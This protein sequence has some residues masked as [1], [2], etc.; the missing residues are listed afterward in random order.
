[1][2][3]HQSGFTLIELMIVVAIIAILAAIAIP[4]YNGY[5]TEANVT[6]VSTAF[7]EGTNAV[8]AEMAKRQAVIARGGDYPLDDAGDAGDWITTVLNPDANT[9]PGADTGIFAAAAVDNDGIIGV[10]VDAAHA[11][12]F[13]LTMIRPIFDPAGDSTGFTAQRSITI[14]A[15]S[16]VTVNGGGGS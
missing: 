7:E 16:L 2:K 10:T 11:T 4:A 3:K 8:K 13:A 14:D 15:N 9:A 12:G 5:I 1:M 6:R